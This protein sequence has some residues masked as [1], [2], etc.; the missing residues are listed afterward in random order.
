MLSEFIDKILDTSAPRKLTVDDREYFTRNL[1]PVMEPMP[2]GLQITTL[3]GLVDFIHDLSEIDILIHVLSCTRVDV[4]G[5]LQA[6][7]M[8]RKRYISAI[9]DPV[10]LPFDRW[11]E[12]E[13][14]IIALQSMFV[15]S[16]SINDILSLVGNLKDGT[17]K[18]YNDTGITQVV[19]AKT[20]V[21]T[22]D[23]IAVPNPVTL[24]P[25]RTFNEVEQ[26]ESLF[27]FRMR[28]CPEGGTPTCLL[29]EADGGKWRLDAILQI[30]EWLAE[31]LPDIPIIA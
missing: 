16:A 24:Q 29:T 22:V 6:K 30:R 10:N 31:A 11:L 14:F 21:A 17:V 12:L 28:S 5:H 13:P 1:F 27:V 26:P 2:E 20:G 7:F 9:L 4:I 8:Q 19:T 25:Y 15:Q 3:T 18:N 23:E